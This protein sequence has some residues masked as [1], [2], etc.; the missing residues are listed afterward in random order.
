MPA[1]IQPGEPPSQGDDLGFR[2]SLKRKIG[3]GCG[4]VIGN[5]GSSNGSLCMC[6]S[7]R[8]FAPAARAWLWPQEFVCPGCWLL[9]RLGVYAQL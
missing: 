9:G 4:V 6:A 2:G 5:Q 7:V 8:A 3:I 1:K